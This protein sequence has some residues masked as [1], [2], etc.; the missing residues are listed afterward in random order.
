MILQIL[1]IDSKFFSVLSYPIYI[2]TISLLIAVLI[3][4]KEVNGARSWFQVGSLRIQPAEF[5]KFAT[6]LAIA[7]LL[8]TYNFK[9]FKFLC[10]KIIYIFFHNTFTYFG[11]EFN[12]MVLLKQVSF[13]LILL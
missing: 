13:K 11:C 4:G 3:F 6:N 10:G 8:S 5:A 7:Q 12:K 9:I 2:L 1:M